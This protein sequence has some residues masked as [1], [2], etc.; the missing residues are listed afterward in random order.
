MVSPHF[1]SVKIHLNFHYNKMTEKMYD[2]KK[3]KHKNSILQ[4]LKICDMRAPE[5]LAILIFI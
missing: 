4:I 2:I 3:E 1:P 5:R